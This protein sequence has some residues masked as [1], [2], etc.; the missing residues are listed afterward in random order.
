LNRDRDRRRKDIANRECTIAR[1]GRAHRVVRNAR[2]GVMHTPTRELADTHAGFA[3]EDL[4]LGGMMRTPMAG[5]L[6]DAGPGEAAAQPSACY[7]PPAKV[8]RFTYD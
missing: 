2:K 6:A 7:S 5:S 8:R 4:S 3:V 1:L